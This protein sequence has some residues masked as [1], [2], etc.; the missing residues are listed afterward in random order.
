MNLSKSLKMLLTKVCNLVLA[1]Y[2]HYLLLERKTYIFVCM[3]M[4][5]LLPLTRL[6]T[7]ASQPDT[8]FERLG[9]KK[10]HVSEVAS[11]FKLFFREMPDSLLQHE[12][13]DCF[14]SVYGMLHVSERSLK[15]FLKQFLLNRG[16]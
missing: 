5:C 8:N 6:R 10:A 13:Y 12:L 3:C 9:F 2:F 4:N 14:I 11:L 15:S 7:E 16:D 1:Y